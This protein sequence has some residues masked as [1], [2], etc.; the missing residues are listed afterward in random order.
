[1]KLYRNFAAELVQGR[2]TPAPTYR[3]VVRAG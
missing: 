2:L 3:A 1:V